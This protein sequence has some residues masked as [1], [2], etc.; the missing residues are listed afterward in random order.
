MLNGDNHL[1]IRPKSCGFQPVALRMQ[2]GAAAVRARHIM[3]VGVAIADVINQ[4]LLDENDN[5]VNPVLVQFST[6]NRADAPA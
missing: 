3:A 5:A 2:A 6:S 4:Y 1:C